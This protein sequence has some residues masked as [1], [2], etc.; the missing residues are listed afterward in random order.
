MKVSIA[1]LDAIETF[2]NAKKII[3]LNNHSIKNT[4]NRSL[5]HCLPNI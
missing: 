4:L 1:F 5:A 2:F 3:K